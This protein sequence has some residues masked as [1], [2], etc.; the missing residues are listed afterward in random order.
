LRYDQE[1][2]SFQESGPITARRG[3]LQP[4]AAELEPGYLVSYLRR[5][6]DYLPTD[7]GWIVRSESRDG[8]KTW[9]AGT[10]TRFPNPNSAVDFLKLKS[11][12]L[13]LVFNE[14]MNERTPLVAALSA[15]SDQSY[16]RRLLLAK[17]PGDFAYPFAIQAADGRICVAY[18]AEERTVIMLAEFEESALK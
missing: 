7:D 5:G 16:P 6:G 9:T 1:T 2:H 8:G 14:S 11:G 17:G 15:D 18:T 12:K 10:D 3:C 4:A 13:L